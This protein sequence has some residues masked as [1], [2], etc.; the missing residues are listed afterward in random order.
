MKG[1][2]TMAVNGA[3][4]ALPVLDYALNHGD[5]LGSMLGEKGAVALSFLALV[6]M[7]LRWVTNSPV[8]KSV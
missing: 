4:A 8:F 5:M 1:F 3:V 2:K 6:N 7:V